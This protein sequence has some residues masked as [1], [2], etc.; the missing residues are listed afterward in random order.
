MKENPSRKAGFNSH[1]YS[2]QKNL[3]KLLNKNPCLNTYH[4]ERIM[5]IKNN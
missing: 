2:S 1:D 5:V 3:K 4:I